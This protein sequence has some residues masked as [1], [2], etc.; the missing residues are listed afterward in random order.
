M[1]V[2][3]INPPIYD[4]N[5]YDVWIKP[6]GLL[7]ISNILKSYNIEVVLLDC[8]DRNYFEEIKVKPDG[9]GKFSYSVVEKPEILSNIPLKYKRYGIDQQKIIDFL[10]SNK[11]ADY[12]IVTSTMTYWYLG[13]KE[14]VELLRTYLANTKILLGGIYPKLML[15]HSYLKFGNLVDC[16]FTTNSV[17]ELLKFLNLSSIENYLNFRN[18]PLPDY[19]SY[20]K[21]WYVVTRFSYGCLNNCD[22]CAARSISTQYQQKSIETFTEEIKNLF[23]LTGAKNFVFY[24]DALFNAKNIDEVKQ[25]FRKL[26]EL[27]VPIKFYTPN[28]INPKFIDKELALLMKE[29]NFTD[30]RLSLETSN[31]KTHNIVDRKINTKE[32]EYGLNNLIDAGYKPQE[33]SVY[34]LAGLPNETLEDVYNSINYVAKYGM[35]VR[36]CEMSPVPKSKLF[37]QLGLDED[38]DPLLHNNSIFLFNGIK[39]KVPAWCSYEDFLRLKNYVKEINS[40]NLN[41]LCVET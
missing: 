1:K 4:F 40:K 18:Y 41:K 32:F 29:L 37:Y 33:I 34:I 26:L 19:S 17:Y 23:Y 36:L 5:A 38:V 7:Y 16:L 12:A 9:T 25:L 6:L 31:N 10:K 30:P 20:K 35:R 21:I 14:I 15:K 13:V 2:L 28:G 27:R 22:Y 3:L 11:D 39:N 24:D 8:L